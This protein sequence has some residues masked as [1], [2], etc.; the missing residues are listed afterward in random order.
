MQTGGHDEVDRCF[1]CMWPCL[2]CH[3]HSPKTAVF[4]DIRYD[5][6]QA[7]SQINTV[8]AETLSGSTVRENRSI[9]RELFAIM[10]S[11]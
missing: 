11:F 8:K 5:N 4:S 9:E 7:F 10:Y 6:C 2:K 1:S 3:Y